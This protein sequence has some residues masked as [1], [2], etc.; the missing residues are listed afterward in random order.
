VIV[1]SR[2]HPNDAGRGFLADVSYRMYAQ[3]F[4]GGDS[5]W[6]RLL[7][8]LRAYRRLTADGRH[9]LAIWSFTDVI[10]SGVAPYLERPAVGADARGRS[11]RGYAEGQIRGDRLTAFEAEYRVML[12]K[13]GLLGLVVFANTT[14]VGDD[15]RGVGLFDSFQPG[16]GAGIR[17]QLQKRSRT[18]LGVDFGVGRNASRRIYVSLS[19]A[20]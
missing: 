20:F 18:N 16:G 12:M 10:T 11:G 17:F 7:I 19:D 3:G 4:L 14:T 15:E 6:Q 9:R 2:D 5:D 1:D 8:D 13:N